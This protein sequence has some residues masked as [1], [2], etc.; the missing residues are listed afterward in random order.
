MN[1]EKKNMK[2]NKSIFIEISIINNLFDFH[3]QHTKL[4]STINA[5]EIHSLEYHRLL[6][7]FRIEPASGSTAAL[8]GSAL[9]M[10]FFQFSLQI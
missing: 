5:H 7:S 6:V 9:K 8:F 10:Y 2:K 1:A 3:M 4:F